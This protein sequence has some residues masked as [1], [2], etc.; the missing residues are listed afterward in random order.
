[1]I[2]VFLWTHLVDPLHLLPVLQVP[3]LPSNSQMLQLLDLTLRFPQTPQT[4]LETLY[5]EIPCEID[6]V[7]ASR[8]LRMDTSRMIKCHFVLLIHLPENQS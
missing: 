8:S 5:I 7:P 4:L 3:T 1:M 6:P 2:T